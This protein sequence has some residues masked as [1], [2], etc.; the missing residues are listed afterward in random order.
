[1]HPYVVEIIPLSQENRFPGAQRPRQRASKITEVIGAKNEFKLFRMS[2]PAKV[3]LPPSWL[4]REQGPSR[5]DA[6]N[7][8]D[9]QGRSVGD[10]FMRSEPPLFPRLQRCFRHIREPAT[11]EREPEPFLVAHLGAF[12]ALVRREIG[13]H[14]TNRD[15]SRSNPGRL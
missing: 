14:L 4:D 11:G 9:I 5:L 8:S 1:M 3:A 2:I 6:R 12:P 7:V 13:Y 10:C 15:K